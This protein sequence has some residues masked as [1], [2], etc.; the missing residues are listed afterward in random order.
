MSKKRKYRVFPKELKVFPIIHRETKFNSGLMLVTEEIPYV[1]SFA[2][3]IG[4]N[5]G[6]RDDLIGL[7]GISHLVEHSVFRRTEHYT[8]SE[9][10]ELFER[11]GAYVNAFTTKEY[12]SFYVRALSPNFKKVWELLFEVVFRPIFQKTDLAKEKSIIKEEIRSYNEDPE[13]EIFDYAD[14]LLYNGCQLSNPIVGYAKNVHNIELDEVVNFYITHYLPSKIVITVVGKLSHEEVLGLIG[15]ELDSLPVLYTA[16][17]DTRT[18]SLNNGIEEKFCKH[19]LQSHF[20]YFCGLPQLDERERLVTAILNI[21]L[22]D[23]T[24]SRLYKNLRE[25]LGLVYNVF[26]SISVYSDNVALYIYSSVEQK[27]LLK[28]RDLIQRELHNI[29]YDGLKSTEIEVAKEQI[30]SSTVIAQENLSER[31]QS[32]IKSQLTFGWNRPFPEII[33]LVDSIGDDEIYEFISRYL[34]PGKWSNIVF[35]PK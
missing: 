34:H 14:K 26:S 6:S 33:P 5:T 9:I 17:S 35:L 20:V 13:E 21:A 32:I 10:N 19:L 28:A 18:L 16:D 15:K 3:G 31:M 29:Y 8:S 12:T 30:K 22:G 11:Y 23:S 27:K 25:K 2:V 7:E 24:S 4:V 1:D